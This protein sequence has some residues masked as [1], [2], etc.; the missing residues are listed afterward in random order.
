[1]SAS[2][3]QLPSGFNPL[4][5]GGSIVSAPKLEQL[6]GLSGGYG[7]QTNGSEP[8]MLPAAPAEPPGIIAGGPFASEPDAPL[9][10]DGHGSG[11]LAKFEK[12]ASGRN[13]MGLPVDEENPEDP[14]NLID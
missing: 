5:L 13:G 12:P 6:L 4:L 10:I 7:T 1:M 3:S 14:I 2:A 8:D 9:T 11:H